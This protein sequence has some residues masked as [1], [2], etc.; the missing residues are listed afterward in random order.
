MKK[1]DYDL[2]GERLFSNYKVRARIE[3]GYSLPTDAATSSQFL[4]YAVRY[5]DQ[6]AMDT[7]LA[8]TYSNQQVF[9][10]AVNALGSNSRNWASFV[11]VRD[12]HL[13]GLLYG[14]DPEKTHTAIL[15]GTLTLADLREHLSGQGG[16]GDAKAIIRWAKLLTDHPNYY[17]Q[18]LGI[19]RA[20]VALA[21]DAGYQLGNQHLMMVLAGYLISPPRRWPGEKHLDSGLV[22]MTHRERDLPGMGYPLASEFLRNLHWNGFKPDRHI[23]RLL[24][25]WVPEIRETVEGDVD[26][27]CAL[28]GSK[29]RSLKY[30]LR[31]SLVGVAIT[32]DGNYSRADNLIWMLGAY[33]EKKNK[34]SNVEYIHE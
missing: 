15:D 4:D 11:K 13:E 6:E 23:T 21:E 28:I 12:Q 7:P 8:Q 27:L 24:E 31:Y 19:A 14:F 17:D 3:R 34:E 20:F 9:K 32:P 2:V 5:L 26:R 29:N 16:A 25:L 30:F 18:I 22:Q 1:L 10:A 33:L